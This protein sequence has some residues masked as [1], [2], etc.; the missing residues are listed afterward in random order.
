MA[1]ACYLKVLQASKSIWSAYS[2]DESFERKT[3]FS[4]SNLSNI[5]ENLDKIVQEEEF[6][7]N[8]LD[9][10]ITIHNE[11]VSK[12]CQIL[13]KPKARSINNNFREKLQIVI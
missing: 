8:Y 12:F 4:V 1:L 2:I 9:T 11:I 10:M 6:I 7:Q 3:N 13:N 5:K